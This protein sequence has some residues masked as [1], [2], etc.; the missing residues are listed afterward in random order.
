M[1]LK[2]NLHTHTMRCNHA[3]GSDREY[4]EAAIKAGIKVLG[5]SDHCPQPYRNGFHSNIRMMFPDVPDYV[6][7]IL[8]LKTEYQ[9]DI[10][11][12]IGYEAEYFPSLF[13]V[14]RKDLTKY[15]CDYLILGSHFIPD[16]VSGFYS[17]SPTDRVEDLIAYV[18]NTIEGLET[19]AFTY[20]AHPDLIH[21][22]GD[23]AIYDKE[24]LRICACAKRENIPLEI[25]MNGVFDH[26]CYPNERFF[27]MA[28]EYGNTFVVGVDA[29]DPH[30]FLD[31]QTWDE[32]EAFLQRVRIVPQETIEIIDPKNN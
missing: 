4:V 32:T 29:H 10:E 27:A 25:N 15:P 7:S 16:E 24:M 9:D 26:R 22:T 28:R 6:D 19:G 1:T 8:N 14:L 18:D 30:A 13:R 3:V 17:G 23:K 12:L 31:E 20:L 2:T 21:F 11:I 5:F